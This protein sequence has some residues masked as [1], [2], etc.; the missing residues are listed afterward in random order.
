MMLGPTLIYKCPDCAGLLCCGSMISGNS[1]GGRYWTDGKATFRMRRRQYALLKCPHCTY[2]IWMD[3]L[4]IHGERDLGRHGVVWNRFYKA[5]RR[6]SEL[7]DWDCHDESDDAEQPDFSGVSGG[8]IPERKDYLRYAANRANEPEK[9]RYARLQ[10]WWDGNDARRTSRCAIALEADEVANLEALAALMEEWDDDDRLM[11]AEILRELGRFAEAAELLATRF[12]PRLWLKA[13]II[14]NLNQEGNAGVAEVAYPQGE[15]IDYSSVA[16]HLFAPF[17]AP[18]ADAVHDTKNP[19]HAPHMMLDTR[20]R[21]KILTDLLHARRAYMTTSHFA[22][23]FREALLFVPLPV[24]GQDS[25]PGFR[26]RLEVM[27]N[28]F[29]QMYQ[30]Y[31]VAPG[32]EWDLERLKITEDAFARLRGDIADGLIDFAAIDPGKYAELRSGR[33]ARAHETFLI[34]ARHVQGGDGIDDRLRDGLVVAAPAAYVIVWLIRRLQGVCESCI[35]YDNESRIV[36]TAVKAAAAFLTQ[37]CQD[38]G[39]ARAVGID[40]RAWCLHVFDQVAASVIGGWQG[41]LKR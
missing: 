22:E 38:S 27:L 9:A 24:T 40:A 35:P 16:P 14:H 2:M 25:K 12:P 5:S 19:L 20:Q 33:S 6:I 13:D 26:H 23:T 39:D 37:Y 29:E 41:G 10:V 17:M 36:E 11:K 28:L 7:D 30:A 21:G 8:I 18:A 1:S 4:D 34:T 32:R 31:S 3:S 15:F